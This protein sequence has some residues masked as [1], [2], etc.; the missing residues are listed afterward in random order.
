MQ[1]AALAEHCRTNGLVEMG[2]LA[3]GDLEGVASGMRALAEA[4]VA[5]LGDSV[6]GTM[7]HAIRSLQT[8]ALRGTAWGF[9]PAGTPHEGIPV[10]IAIIDE[11][12]CMPDYAMPVVL[13]FMP[14]NLVTFPTFCDHRPA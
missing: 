5:D 6:G 8:G 7:M 4:G 2:G 12:G 1:Q 3:A 9:S 13:S 11:A 10:D 14:A